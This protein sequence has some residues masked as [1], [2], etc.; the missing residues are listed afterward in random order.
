MKTQQNS[1]KYLSQIYIPIN[2]CTTCLKE[3]TGREIWY[4][5][6]RKGISKINFDSSS[7]L[8]SI[9][10][11]YVICL[12]LL[13]PTISEIR[14]TRYN[15]IS[16]KK[17]HPLVNSLYIIMHSA[18][19]KTEHLYFMSNWMSSNAFLSFGLWVVCY[20]V[21]DLWP[22]PLK[23]LCWPVIGWNSSGD[24]FQSKDC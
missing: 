23:P 21:S 13:K 8:C 16:L 17:F 9:V 5:R 10:I 3:I 4:P 7:V 19:V 15:E 20:I 6:A 11:T 1:S 22:I 12:L 2:A 24:L 14:F 18:S